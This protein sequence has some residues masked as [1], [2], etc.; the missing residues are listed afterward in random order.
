MQGR[1]TKLNI[2]SKA[3]LTAFI[4]KGAS[5]FSPMVHSAEIE[6][7]TLTKVQQRGRVVCGVN[8]NLLGFSTAN[9]LG[10]Y[11]G[12]DI[13][14]CR[15]VSAAVF[16]DSEKTDFVPT[17]A[18]NRFNDLV[19]EEFDVLIRNTTWTLDRNSSFGNFAGVN[20]YDGQGFMVWKRSGIRSSLE[21]DNISV[22]VSRGTTSELNAADYFTINKLRYKPNF[23]DDESTAIEAYVAGKCDALT[24]DR[25]A[26]AATR[27]FQSDPDAHRILADV[28]SKEPLGPMVRT[29]DTGWENVVRWSL[30]CMINAEEI[31][32]DSTNVDSVDDSSLPREQR[33]VGIVGD[34]GTKLGLNNSWCADI[35]RSVGNYSESYDRN[36]GVDSPL[37]VQ[38][39]VNSLWTNGGLIYA[40]PIR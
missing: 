8:A 40:P 9:S 4:L 18:V 5:L 10:E 16:G 22:C 2:G 23:Y 29:N 25:S 17:S 28:I 27:V 11:T 1:W 6:S 24:T 14:L 30:N 39:G 13:D 33:L 34:F 20:F 21:L 36:V 15:A 26:L 32:V 3:V 7:A 19:N 38:R 35:I 31:G 12:L 37:E